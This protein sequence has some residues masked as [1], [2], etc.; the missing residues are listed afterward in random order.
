MMVLSKLRQPQLSLSNLREIS[1]FPKLGLKQIRLRHVGAF[2]LAALPYILYLLFLKFYLSLR[3]ITHLDTL[4]PPTITI[5]PTIE[6]HIFFCQPHKI[7]SQLAN[8]FFDILAAIPYLVHFPLPFIFGAYLAF[9]P[10]KRRG[11]FSYMWCAGWINFLAVLFQLT[12]P[13]ASPWFVDSAIL[14]EHGKVIYEYP[15]EAGFKRLDAILGFGIFHGIYSQSPLKFGAFPSLHIAWPMI[16]FLNN[17]WFGKKF[18]ALHVL[19]I[20]LAANYSTHHYLID[21]VGGIL[22]CVIVKLCI[23]KIWSPFPEPVES[24]GNNGGSGGNKSVTRT[25]STV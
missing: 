19:W 9:N 1:R 24:N 23:L 4:S 14:D 10:G 6:E 11:L 12:F 20:T 3:R 17:P 7:L 21:A 5:L 18:A 15:N 8:P 16:V 13:T 2:L 22:L 25:A